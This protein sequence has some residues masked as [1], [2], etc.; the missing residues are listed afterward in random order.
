MEATVLL[1][2]G[3]EKVPCKQWKAR[4][5]HRIPAQAHTALSLVSRTGNR[6]AVMGLIIQQ[7]LGPEDKE[8]VSTLRRALLRTRPVVYE[9]V[10]QARLAQ[11]PVVIE[12]ENPEALAGR[13]ALARLVMRKLEELALPA[14]VPQPGPSTKAKQSSGQRGSRL[15]KVK[16]GLEVRRGNV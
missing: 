2:Q 14:Q 12:V 10:Q 5:V 3:G 9:L 6:I 1:L 7:G 16:R 8:K 15:P 13:G 11:L 4:V